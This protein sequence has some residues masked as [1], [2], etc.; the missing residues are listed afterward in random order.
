MIGFIGLGQIGAPMARRIAKADPTLLVYDASPLAV[1]R[2]SDSGALAA[3]S[4][5]GVSEQC[6]VVSVMVNTDE[7]VREVVGE[8]L[9]YPRSGAVIALH[10]TIGATTAVEL[11]ELAS[12]VG[13]EVV[14]A[15]VSG[16]AMGASQGTLAVMFGGTDA[17]VQR[18]RPVFAHWASLVSHFGA[19]GAGTKA[20]LARNLL[21]FTAFSV[22]GEVVR[23]AEAAGLSP[24]ELG[25]VVRHSDAVTGGPGA[26]M[27]RNTSAALDHDDGL[28]PIF[29]HTAQLGAKDTS[30]ALELA[31]SLGVEM[32]IA[33]L[34]SNYLTT[35]LGLEGPRD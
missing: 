10:S 27:I 34:A 1:E 16:G 24:L 25:K 17:A 12:K 8:L 23:L 11:N 13:V 9:K 30:L 14:D 35:A 22:V 31:A 5:R 2:F 6:D 33:S 19:V 21:H 20:K 28:R 7:Q 26:I 29:A 15:P 3:Q 4:L 18:C 32:P